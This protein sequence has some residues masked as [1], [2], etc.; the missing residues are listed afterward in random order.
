MAT[1]ELPNINVWR[2]DLITIKRDRYVQRLQR[3]VHMYQTT[4]V[5]NAGLGS[6]SQEQH[7]YTDI[8][9]LVV[10][11]NDAVMAEI[12]DDEMRWLNGVYLDHRK[13]NQFL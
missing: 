4:C 10:V 11:F 13:A 9:V 8:V 12:Y 5:Q 6:E 1:K 7:V 2:T 3:A